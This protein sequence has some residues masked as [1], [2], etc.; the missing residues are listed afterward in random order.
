[1]RLKSSG[2]VPQTFLP[3]SSLRLPNAVL[4]H[5]TSNGQSAGPVSYVVPPCR[6]LNAA[7]LSS[8]VR[9]C[10]V[11]TSTSISKCVG[12]A[13]VDGAGLVDVALQLDAAALLD[14]MRGLVRR[15]V[16]IGR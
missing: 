2:V 7:S 13:L 14:D 8:L 10:S 11:L 4:N 12:V 9:C 16:Q 1:M 3:Y 15:G 6:P 5:E